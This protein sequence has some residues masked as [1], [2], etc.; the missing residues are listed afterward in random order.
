[1]N[2]LQVL[3][4]EMILE[5]CKKMDLKTRI[6][7]KK[8]CKFMNNF[9]VN[10][11]NLITE[12]QIKRWQEKIKLILGFGILNNVI[13]YK[14][15]DLSNAYEQKIYLDYDDSKDMVLFSTTYKTTLILNKVVNS[16]S[17]YHMEQDGV[18]NHGQSGMLFS[19]FK[20]K[21]ELK[22]PN[23]KAFILTANFLYDLYLTAICE[24]QHKNKEK[25]MKQQLAQFFLKSLEPQLISKE[26]EQYY[27]HSK[28]LI[29]PCMMNMVSSEH[30]KKIDDIWEETAKEVKG[31]FMD[32][33]EAFQFM[34]T[35][36]L[37]L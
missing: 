1:M 31:Y 18:S 10:P 28:F 23:E 34:K 5:C 8:T 30:R 35:C 6:N 22:E 13:T 2:I 24:W 7:F 19:Q 4:D 12:E 11:K 20:L 26:I 27:N 32:G 16:Y 36:K 37:L 17:A 33:E 15:V 25:V 14:K 29:M 3:P 9:L 21:N